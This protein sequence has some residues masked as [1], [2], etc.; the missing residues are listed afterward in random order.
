MVRSSPGH[1]AGLFD[2]KGNSDKDNLWNFTP[3][4][5]WPESF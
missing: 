4:V 1:V 5:I 3:G 2:A